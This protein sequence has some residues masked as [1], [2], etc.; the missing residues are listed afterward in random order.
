[1]TTLEDLN[2]MIESY[3]YGAYQSGIYDREEFPNLT[4]GQLD[5]MRHDRIREHINMILRQWKN[6]PHT[7][8][9]PS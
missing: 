2:G 9:I 5:E 7:N 8:S 1:M 4:K 3:L 6:I